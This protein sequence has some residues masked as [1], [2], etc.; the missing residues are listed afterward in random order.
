MVIL[1]IGITVLVSSASKCLSIVRKARTYGTAQELLARVE[2]ENPIHVLEKIEEANGSGSFSGDY[3]GYRWT[4]K[5]EPIGIEKDGLYEMHTRVQWSEH[6]QQNGEEVV[7]Y[8]YAPEETL[9][10]SVES[11]E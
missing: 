10:G 2:L 8:V 9:E 5:V 11:A 3:D 4:R 7:T 6:G 1:G